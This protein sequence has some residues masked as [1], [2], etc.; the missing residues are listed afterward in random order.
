MRGLALVLG[1]V[2]ILGLLLGVGVASAQ[3]PEGEA[4]AT[5]VPQQVTPE[6]TAT[7]APTVVAT[8]T[9]AAP[10]AASSVVPAAAPDAAQPAIPPKSQV[11]TGGIPGPWDWIALVVLVG[12]IILGLILFLVRRKPRTAVEEK[13]VPQPVSSTSKKEGLMAT[14]EQELQQVLRELEHYKAALD[15][16]H[17]LLRASYGEIAAL[18]GGIAKW[19]AAVR[20]RDGIINNAYGEIREMGKTIEGLTQQVAEASKRIADMGGPAAPPEAAGGDTGVIAEPPPAPVR[21]TP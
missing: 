16:R 10:A 14:V 2:L 13:P 12:A 1:L 18:K 15:D 21:T 8:P 19:E 6:P 7:T 11:E 3:G 17:R 4:T 5:G 9:V 20:E